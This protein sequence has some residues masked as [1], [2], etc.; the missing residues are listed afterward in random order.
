MEAILKTNKSKGSKVAELTYK[1]LHIINKV[2]TSP[3]NHTSY[4][5]IIAFKKNIFRPFHLL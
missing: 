4:C 1:E 5:I 2:L 3:L